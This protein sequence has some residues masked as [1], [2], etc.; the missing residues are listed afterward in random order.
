MYDRPVL[1]SNRRADRNHRAHLREDNEEVVGWHWGHG[2]QLQTLL[3]RQ[4]RHPRDIPDAPLPL[5]ATLEVL[6][7]TLIAVRD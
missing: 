2:R 5:T 4:L 3:V 6:V 1:S 7:E